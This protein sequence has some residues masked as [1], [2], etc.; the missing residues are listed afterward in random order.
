[1]KK[2]VQR[3]ASTVTRAKRQRRS[4]P[5]KQARHRQARSSAQKLR[6]YYDSDSG[7]ASGELMMSIAPNDGSIETAPVSDFPINIVARDGFGGEPVSMLLSRE[8]I[9]QLIAHLGKVV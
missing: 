3:K 7:E 1:M 2:T 6:L 5:A 4:S 8:D 9:A